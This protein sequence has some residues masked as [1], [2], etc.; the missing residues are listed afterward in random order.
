MPKIEITY[1]MRDQLI[2]AS[3]LD[4]MKGLY[5]EIEELKDETDLQEHQIQDLHDARMWLKQLK[6]TYRYYSY[7]T[8]ALDEFVE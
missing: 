2:L 3:L 7:D 4:S 5:E 6:K 8:S 1:E